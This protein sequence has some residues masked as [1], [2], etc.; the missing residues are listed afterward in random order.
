M[1]RLTKAQRR[2]VK[3]IYDRTPLD[4]NHDRLEPGFNDK[5]TPVTYREF[6]QTVQ[7][8][9]C[10]DAVMIHWCNMFLGIESDGY[11]HS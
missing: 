10:S 9:I 4:I 3:R 6:R 8:I 11:T 5:C 7:P 1:I 2:A